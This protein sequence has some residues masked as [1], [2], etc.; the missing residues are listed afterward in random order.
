ML[1]VENEDKINWNGI[2]IFLF[3]KY[4]NQGKIPS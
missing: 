3:Q 1:Q 4:T 2:D